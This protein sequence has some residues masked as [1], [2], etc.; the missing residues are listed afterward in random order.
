MS[1]LLS[2]STDVLREEGGLGS[3]LVSM[4][5]GLVGQGILQTTTCAAKDP[6]ATMDRVIQVSHPMPTS[7][8]LVSEAQAACSQCCVW[9]R[10][11]HPCSR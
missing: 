9:T 3:Q 8:R 10:V 6:S 5:S 7:Q 2:P 4:L 1:R 11:P